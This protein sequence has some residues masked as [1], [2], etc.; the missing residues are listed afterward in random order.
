MYEIE[1]AEATYSKSK[2]HPLT[3]FSVRN[4]Y[5]WC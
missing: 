5:Y 3:M 2:A 4:E 1:L